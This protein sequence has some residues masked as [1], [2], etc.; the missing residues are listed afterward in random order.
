MKKLKRTS[1]G[2]LS[3]NIF[4]YEGIVSSPFGHISVT[5]M[6]SEKHDTLSIFQWI[7]VWMSSG[8]RPPNEVVSDYSRALLAAISRAFCDGIG[9]NDYVNYTFKVLIGVEKKI[10]ATYIRLDV[11]HMVK[12]F[13]RIKC[14][15]GV[16]SKYLKEFYVRG[17]RLLMTSENLKT[18]ETILEAFLTVMLS[19]TD[20]WSNNTET[21][22][23]TAKSY[24]LEL[25][26]GVSVDELENDTT[27]GSKLLSDFDSNIDNDGNEDTHIQMFL[28]NIKQKSINNSLTVGNRISAYFLKD[29]LPDT[30]RLCKH[31]PLWTNVL[32]NLFQSPYRMAS[33][34]SVENDFKELKTQILKFDVRPMRADK[35]IFKHLTSINSNVKLF[36]SKEL[37]YGSSVELNLDDQC[38]E[39]PGNENIMSF[40]KSTVYEHDTGELINNSPNSSIESIYETTQNHKTEYNNVMSS[41]FSDTSINACENWKGKGVVQELFPKNK[42]KNLK[43]PRPTKYM[44]PMKDIERVLSTVKTRSTLNSL[45]INGN[46]A[47]PII[48]SKKRYL[49]QNTCPFDALSVL[50]ATAYTDVLSYQHFVDKSNNCFLQFCKILSLKGPSRSIYKQRVLLLKKIFEVDSGVT[51]IHLINAR[52]NVNYMASK[53]LIDEPSAYETKIC[54]NCGVKKNFQNATIVTQIPNGLKT[55]E[56]GLNNYVRR[57]NS[58]C[59][60]CTTGVMETSRVLNSHLFIETDLYSEFTSYALNEYPEEVNID[61]NR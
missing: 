22:S 44:G 52:C 24:I 6:V 46:L 5:Q 3:A 56:E 35:F 36:K 1:L 31:F 58:D 32:S 60:D 30:M 2:L 13:C 15:T 53:Y 55:I 45:L 28:E 33:S 11:A 54:L 38:D 16:K 49:V 29:L 7:A 9:V 40:D 26:K 25:I 20:G 42:K 14:L 39:L 59:S 50:V 57:I 8:L 4:L 23:E 61:K 51:D 21:P 41:D 19:E 37:R 10:P 48:V 43:K 27:S 12:I 17:F 47:T 18:F 34:A